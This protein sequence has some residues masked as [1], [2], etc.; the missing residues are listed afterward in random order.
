MIEDNKEQL[1]SDKV[2]T[3]NIFF[4]EACR[5]EKKLAKDYS[6]KTE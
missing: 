1:R 4:E 3:L 5:L 2:L 6:L